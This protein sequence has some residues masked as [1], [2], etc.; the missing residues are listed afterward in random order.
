MC[1]GN[2]WMVQRLH[3]RDPFVCVE[4][5]HLLQQVDELPSVGLL[6][7]DVSPL[8]VS[9]VHLQRDRKFVTVPGAPDVIT[10]IQLK[11]CAYSWR[12]DLK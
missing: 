7:Q 3:G 11:C 8:Q 9:H 2:E 6:C 10:F 5:Q 12:G 1:H 4:R